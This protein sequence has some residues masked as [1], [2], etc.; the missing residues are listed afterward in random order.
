MAA[1][2]I[3]GRRAALVGA[4]VI[5]AVWVLLYPDAAQGAVDQAVSVVQGAIDGA[6]GA[7]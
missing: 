3:D 2:F 4:L 7:T 5:I 6:T 1:I